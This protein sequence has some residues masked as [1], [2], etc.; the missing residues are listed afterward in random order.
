MIEQAAGLRR[1]IEDHAP[2][3]GGETMTRHWWTKHA[4]RASRTIFELTR[5]LQRVTEESRDLLAR[6][7]AVNAE[8][9]ATRA[10]N[11]RLSR[12][13]RAFSRAVGVAYEF[14]SGA[15]ARVAGFNM[16]LMM[17]GRPMSSTIT[18]IGGFID[19]GAAHLQR[20]MRRHNVEPVIQFVE[21]DDE[22]E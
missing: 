5:E 17:T 10:E 12:E 9:A 14:L 7:D 19:R 16:G 3:R 4:L 13:N 18:S 11:Y 20:F 22:K 8:L 15:G 2:M 21:D 6:L 1:V